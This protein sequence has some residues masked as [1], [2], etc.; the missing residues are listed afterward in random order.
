LSWGLQTLNQGLAPLGLRLQRM[1]APTRSFADFGEQLRRQGMAIKT[2]VDVGVGP[3]TPPLYQS[4]PSAKF[5]LVEPLEENRGALKAWA[6]RLNAEVII[7]AAGAENGEITIHVHEDLT[8]SS[9]LRQ[10][11]GAAADGVA[12]KVPIV[13]LDAVMTAPPARPCLV[14]LDTQGTELAVID[15]LGDRLAEVDV[16]IIETSFLPFREGAAQFADVVCRLA[17]LGFAVYDILE[18]HMRA[19]DGALAQV[20]LVAVPLDSPLRRDP[21]FFSDEQLRSY[22]DRWR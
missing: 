9:V 8:G 7:A 18:G 10:A 4:F 1:P 11:E 22:Q 20:D 13:R 3:G 5:F 12:R 6:E 16:F 14:K 19:L 21:R 2:V 17:D 15:G